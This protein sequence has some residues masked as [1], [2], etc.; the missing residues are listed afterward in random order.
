MSG[1]GKGGK[2]LGKGGAKRHR[3]VLRDNIQGITKPDYP[4]SR[5]SWRCQAY[6]GLDLR[7]DP[8]CLEGVPREHHPWCCYLHRARQAKDR[9]RHGCCLRFEETGPYPLRFRC[10]NSLFI[11]M[12]AMQFVIFQQINPPALFE[13]TSNLIK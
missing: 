6:L 11:K 8:W 13:A 3:K 1:C 10:V 9:Y 4:S 2:G 5:T 7:G 12:N